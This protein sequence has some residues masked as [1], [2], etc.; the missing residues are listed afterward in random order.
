MTGLS[1][2]QMEDKFTLEAYPKL[3]FALVRG[4][5][6]YVYDQ[7]GRRYLDLYGG[8]AVSSLG[9]SHP[10]WVEAIS[11]QAATLD[12]YSNICYHPLRAEAA[13]RLVRLSYPSMTG[14]YFCNSGAEANETALKLARKLTGRPLVA[15]LDEGFH[16][17]TLG[18]LSVTGSAK[19]RHAFPEN[20]EHLTRFVRLGDLEAIEALDARQIAAV[21]L[22]P[23]QSLAGVR[24]ASPDY[25]QGL[26]RYCSA[27]GIVLIF[28]EVQTGNG[29]TG[30]WFVGQH[31]DVEPD[32][33]TT[34]KGVAG[35]FPVGAVIANRRVAAD[36]KVGDQGSTFGG[37]PMAAAAVNITYRIL[38]E[39]G[40]VEQVARRSQQVIAR[41]RAL[42]GRGAV[43]EV[44]GLG[45]LLGVECEIEA[46]TLQARLR[47]RGVLVGTSKQ[48]QTIGVL[49]R[50]TVREGE[51]EEFFEALERA[52]G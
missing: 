21:I 28:D 27:H 4:D 7:S 36:V 14:A 40:I 3:D 46:K 44:R 39:E 42:A 25:Y 51:W 26:R 33:V 22:E 52:L 11:R 5:G 8:H 6:S 45:Y 9:H 12:F 32:I 1:A 16:G 35:G 37:G 23:I 13:E 48:A 18:A 29:R 24:M 17:R 47:E 41:L 31:W 30:K 50:L 34:A 49:P 2:K 19:L 43:R 10:R 38:E 20:L 15:A